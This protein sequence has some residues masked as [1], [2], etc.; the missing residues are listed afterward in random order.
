MEQGHAPLLVGFVVDGPTTEQRKAWHF[1]DEHVEKNNNI[2]C[3]YT[4]YNPGTYYAWV[5]IIDNFDNVI[6][7]GYEKR[8]PIRV[9]EKNTKITSF[10]QWEGII[11]L[12]EYVGFSISHNMKGDPL[13]KWVWGDGSSDSSEDR[14][15][16]LCRLNPFHQYHKKGL[17]SGNVTITDESGNSDSKEFGVLVLPSLFEIGGNFTVQFFRRYHKPTDMPFPPKKE[18]TF[19]ANPTGGHPEYNFEWI[20]GVGTAPVIR[21]SPQIPHSFDHPGNYPVTLTIKDSYGLKLVISKD[22]IIRQDSTS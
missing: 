22:V 3:N 1:G 6:E 17:F 2:V 13:I 15:F 12:E 19:T 5:D 18:L 21:S 10:N 16:Y 11:I 8:I 7:S 9:E 4:Y 14:N 20:F